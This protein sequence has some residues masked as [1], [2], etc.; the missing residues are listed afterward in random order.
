MKNPTVQNSIKGLVNG[1]SYLPV[2]DNFIKNFNETY[3]DNMG[4]IQNSLLIALMKAF[5]CKINSNLNL[6]HGTTVTNFFLS[7]AGTGSKAAL[8]LVSANPGH[9]ILMSHIQRLQVRMSL[10]SSRVNLI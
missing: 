1:E 10:I 6:I 4:N 9:S 5:I 3:M 2:G 7:L 8:E